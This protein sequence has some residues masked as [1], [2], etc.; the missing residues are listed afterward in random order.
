MQLI[1]RVL[2]HADDAQ[3]K[4][5]TIFLHSLNLIGII[6]NKAS[7]T[8]APAAKTHSGNTFITKPDKIW[9]DVVGRR[10]CRITDETILWQHHQQLIH[11]F[12]CD[13][14]TQLF[15]R[16]PQNNHNACG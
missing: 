3:A 6:A 15:N 2:K 13:P 10:Y 11:G 1:Y 12:G 14:T 4:L 9:K 16:L 5:F 7:A 8:L